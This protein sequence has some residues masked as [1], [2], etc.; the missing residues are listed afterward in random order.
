MAIRLPFR[1][2]PG[3][4]SVGSNQTTIGVGYFTAASMGLVLPLVLGAGATQVTDPLLVSGWDNFMLFTIY[5]GGGGTTTWEYQIVDPSTQAALINRGIS[6]AT[7]PG[8]LIFTF[9]AQSAT[10]PAATRGDAF[11]LIT[12]RITAN[13]AG[14]TYSAIQLWCGVR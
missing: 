6:A 8:T 7:A 12:L 9:G 10:A 4:A 11:F 14:Q 2:A 13:A 3:Y 1:T 5:A